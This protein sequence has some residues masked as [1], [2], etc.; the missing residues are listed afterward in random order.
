MDIQWFFIYI[1][2]FI[3]FYMENPHGHVIP[4]TTVTHQ[5]WHGSMILLWTFWEGP[6]AK[7]VVNAL[8]AN[9]RYWELGT[10]GTDSDMYYILYVYI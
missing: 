4:V 5:N 9:N 1:F 3:Y 7:S 10:A 8:A 2:I 6:A